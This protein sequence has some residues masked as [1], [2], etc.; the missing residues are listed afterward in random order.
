MSHSA[1]GSLLAVALPSGT[2]NAGLPESAREIADVSGLYS[3]AV[4]ITPEHATFAAFSD[5]AP[6]ANVIHIAGHTR[7]Q[8]GEAGTA[9]LFADDRVTWT[10]IALE[11]LPRAPV[12]VLAAC[13]TLREH[14]APNVRSMTLGDGF[15]AAGATDVIGTLTPIAD[16]DARDL[17]QSI[18]RHL[19]A[20]SAAADA[21]RAAQIEALARQ[22]NAW[23]S[24]ESLTRCI[25]TRRS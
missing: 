21:V 12:V 8:S 2:S 24:I 16:A 17:F 25:N 19:A 22:S 7:Q 5:A 14:A 23:R 15:L 10:S 13:E 18:H 9:L 1:S 11:H 20:G 4:T 6:D 3:S